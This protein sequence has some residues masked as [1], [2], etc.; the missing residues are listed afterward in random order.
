VQ[1]LAGLRHLGHLPDDVGDLIVTEPGEQVGEAGRRLDRNHYDLVIAHDPQ[2]GVLGLDA[3]IEQ[4]HQA[5]H[6]RALAV[7]EL[8]RDKAQANFDAYA[9]VHEELVAQ[10]RPTITRARREAGKAEREFQA[11][12]DEHAAIAAAAL[13]ASR[14]SLSEEADA[15]MRLETATPIPR[16]KEKAAT[17]TAA[18]VAR[19]MAPVTASSA[20]KSA[21]EN[22]RTLAM[23]AL[24]A[25]GRTGYGP[26]AITLGLMR[27][28]KGGKLNDDERLLAGQVALDACYRGGVLDMLKEQIRAEAA[29]RAG[30]REGRPAVHARPR[31]RRP[32]GRDPQ[33]VQRRHPAALRPAGGR[34]PAAPGPAG[35]RTGLEPP[36]SVRGRASTSPQHRRTP[37][38]A[39][40][41]HGRRVSHAPAA[42]RLA[43][44]NFQPDTTPPGTRSRGRRRVPEFDPVITRPRTRAVAPGWPS[45]S[46][47]ARLAGASLEEVLTRISPAHPGRRG[48][49]MPD[50]ETGATVGA[51]PARPVLP[52]PG[53]P[54]LLGTANTATATTSV[55]TSSGDGLDGKTTANGKSGVSGTD[56]SSGG[57]Y[58]VQ[59]SLGAHER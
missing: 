19:A 5:D 11:A 12:Q 1:K 24:Q 9:K 22:K 48:V 50:T 29:R 14:Y 57:G 4:I 41:I 26:E 30:E 33:P 6:I 27:L 47:S 40:R 54:V 2:I 38:P 15:T 55:S 59:G 8:E 56:V 28:L 42:R 13:T 10:H 49:A 35:R 45:L 36:V 43:A 7:L 58:G 23:D 52:A 31:S 25:A 51:Q 16:R 46:W 34:Q 37:L 39:P 3:A 17:D 32:A 53:S 20:Q 21:L 44:R 18:E